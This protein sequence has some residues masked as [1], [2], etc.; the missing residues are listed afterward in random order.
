MRNNWGALS[1]QRV[2]NKTCQDFTKPDIDY[3][4]LL[5]MLNITRQFEINVIEEKLYNLGIIF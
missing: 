5:E 3:E 1:R 2:P 4:Y